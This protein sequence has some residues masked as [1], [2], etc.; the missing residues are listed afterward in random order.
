MMRTKR[1]KSYLVV[2]GLFLGTQ[3]W[4][5]HAFAGE[6]TVKAAITAQIVNVDKNKPARIELTTLVSSPYLLK[7]A[8]LTV[9]A[10]GIK[11]SSFKEKTSRRACKSTTCKQRFQIYLKATTA[12]R[13]EA[14]E[15]VKDGVCKLVKWNDTKSNP[16]PK[17]KIANHSP[18]TLNQ[19]QICYQLTRT[20]ICTCVKVV[21]NLKN[22]IL[23]FCIT[24]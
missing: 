2:V 6:P 14:L 13:S 23:N 24:Y 22:L 11:M 8:G 12:C 17:L 18:K 5:G 7:T 10:T 4:A 21:H 16:P 19:T 1:V 20:H 3:C 9:Q 15:Q